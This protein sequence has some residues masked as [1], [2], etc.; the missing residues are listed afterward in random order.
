MDLLAAEL[1]RASWFGLSLLAHALLLLLLWIIVPDPEVGARRPATVEF[2]AADEYASDGTPTLPDVVAEPMEAPQLPAEAMDPPRE[3]S[4]APLPPLQPNRQLSTNPLLPSRKNGGSATAAPRGS[5]AF[6]QALGSLRVTGLEIVFVFDSTGSMTRTIAETKDT[7]HEMLLV[8]GALVPD[9][10]IG[11]VTYRDRGELEDYVTRSVP[12]SNDYFQAI[13]FV[14]DV[15]AEGGGDLPEAVR[16]GLEC[17]MAQ[18]WREAA[19]RVIVLAGDAPPHADEF[20]NLLR[21][22]RAFSGNGRSFVHTML[23]SL[24]ATDPTA[25]QLFAELAHAGRGSAVQ[26][27]QR[28][29]ILEEVL[30]LA[31]GQEFRG[32]L[33]QITAQVVADRDFVDTRSLALARSG[34][35]PLAD[36]LRLRPVAPSL[37]NALI[38]LPRRA[39]YGQLLAM[40]QAR[41]TPN[42]T[43][44]A[45]AWVL[46]QALRL[47]ALPIDVA[48]PRQLAPN[49]F[50]QARRAVERLRD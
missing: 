20:A 43:R 1:R 25:K 11:M 31:F 38:R 27:R 7:M 34:G 24:H 41:D 21:R 36:A 9:A 8:L 4:A 17:A 18:P 47:P 22:V 15:A 50:D 29:R 6:Q 42:H 28:D 30:T 35:R 44:Q 3:T 13:N 49:C 14:H 12:L 37:V 45:I 19:R 16:E 48:D 2:A 33:D 46:Q 32:D 23:T 10:R 26:L 5:Q 40:L 39:V